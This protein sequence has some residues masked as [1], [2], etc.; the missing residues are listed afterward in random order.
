MGRRAAGYLGQIGRTGGR[1]GNPLCTRDIPN[2]RGIVGIRPPAGQGALA[3][4]AADIADWLDRECE[5]L[6]PD[7]EACTHDEMS[8]EDFIAGGALS[9]GEKRPVQ[10]VAPFFGAC[11]GGRERLEKRRRQVREHPPPWAHPPRLTGSQVLAR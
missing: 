10:P 11:Q 7:W 9:E 3:S 2:H 8:P 4:S 6:W 1:L 5:E